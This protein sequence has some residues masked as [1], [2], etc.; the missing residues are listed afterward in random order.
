MENKSR[1]LEKNLIQIRTLI[2][3]DD[4]FKNV[5]SIDEQ[6]PFSNLLI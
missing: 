3:R 6:K 5:V 1:N 4:L 2:S